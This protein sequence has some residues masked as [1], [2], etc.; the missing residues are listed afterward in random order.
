V[1]GAPGD[2]SYQRDVTNVIWAEATDCGSNAGCVLHVGRWLKAVR[3]MVLRC[4]HRLDRHG[5]WH[6]VQG[7]Q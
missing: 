1:A 2:E 4:E 6:L 7:V 3:H 5:V